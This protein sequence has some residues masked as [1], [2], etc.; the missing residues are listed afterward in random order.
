MP[1]VSDAGVAIKV[2]TK[3]GATGVPNSSST[4]GIIDPTQVAEQWPLPA[5][6]SWSV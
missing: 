5:V 3:L 6:V 4:F 2:V 1:V